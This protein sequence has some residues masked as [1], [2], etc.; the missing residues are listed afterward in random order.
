MRQQMRQ[1]GK[2]APILAPELALKQGLA[3]VRVAIAEGAGAIGCGG[4]EKPRKRRCVSEKGFN[5]TPVEHIDRP[6]R[7]PSPSLSSAAA[8]LPGERPPI[9][10]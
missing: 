5:A 1:G 8:S 4:G 6:A 9:S 2:D 7:S 10:T 3:G